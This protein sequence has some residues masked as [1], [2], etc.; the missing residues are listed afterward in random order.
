V[1]NVIVC[2]SASI[3]LRMSEVCDERVNRVYGG[4]CACVC[5]CAHMCVNFRLHM[6]VS[7]RLF[8]IVSAAV[9]VL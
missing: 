8:I 5:M 6:C 1:W 3:F 9:R 2:V 4:G 7:F